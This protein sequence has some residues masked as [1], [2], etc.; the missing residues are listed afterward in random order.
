MRNWWLAGTDSS[1]PN[2]A[3]NSYYL[4]AVEAILPTGHADFQSGVGSPEALYFKELPWR[5]LLILH[6]RAGLCTTRSRR[7]PG[8]PVAPPAPQRV[9]FARHLHG[10]TASF[11]LAEFLG[12]DEVRPVDERAPQR[13]ASVGECGRIERAASAIRPHAASLIYRD[14]I[15]G[16]EVN[17]VDVC[18]AALIVERN[19]LHHAT[20]AAA[21]VRQFPSE[22]GQRLTIV[23][24]VSKDDCGGL[25]FRF[26]AHDNAR[27]SNHEMVSREHLGV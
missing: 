3:W 11:L 2:R 5:P 15:A 19:F 7:F 22:V 6:H 16:G 14:A 20:D 17:T 26:G 1:Q 4:D 23:L 18:A 12:D 27:C 8:R 25:N 9:C 21:A 13:R 24:V 10:L